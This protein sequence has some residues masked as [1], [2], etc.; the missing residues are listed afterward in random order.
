M[1]KVNFPGCCTAYVLYDLGGTKLSEGRKS[2]LPRK[3]IKDW[4]KA[5]IQECVGCRC[6]VIMTNSDQTVANGVLL[7]LGFKHSAWMSKRQHS[8]SKIRLWWKEP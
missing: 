4:I 3:Q 8:E 6:P 5:M 2:N 1:K 7:E